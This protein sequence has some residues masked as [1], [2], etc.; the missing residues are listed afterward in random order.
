[1]SLTSFVWLLRCGGSNDR[2]RAKLKGGRVKIIQF[3]SIAIGGT[4]VIVNIVNGMV[5]YIWLTKQAWTL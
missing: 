2:C 5:I 3:L 1:V 4:I